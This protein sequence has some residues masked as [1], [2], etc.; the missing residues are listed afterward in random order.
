[1]M[2]NT[3]SLKYLYYGHTQLTWCAGKEFS[4]SMKQNLTAENT[5]VALIEVLED[6][7]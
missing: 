6:I 3:M 7:T 1:M 4:K 5:T 2:V